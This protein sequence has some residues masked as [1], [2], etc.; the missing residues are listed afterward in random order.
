MTSGGQ[1]GSRAL[2]PPELSLLPAGT[3]P[4]SQTEEL[5][6]GR[7]GSEQSVQP[8]SRP[9]ASLG[10]GW[11]GWDGALCSA[12]GEAPL[13]LTA[14]QALTAHPRGTLASGRGAPT[15]PPTHRRAAATA[16]PGLAHPSRLS[17]SVLDQETLPCGAHVT[18]PGGAGAARDGHTFTSSPACKGSWAPRRHPPHTHSALWDLTLGAQEEGLVGKDLP[19]ERQVHWGWGK[20]PLGCP[21]LPT[22]GAGCPPSQAGPPAS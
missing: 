22:S 9:P 14:P 2:Q 16:G 8:G 12:T 19:E 7:G 5:R 4:T 18:R 1:A 11:A 17:F 6:E 15:V 10:L 3:G 13:G 20:Q 21:R